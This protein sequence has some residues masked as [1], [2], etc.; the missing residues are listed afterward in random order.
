[1]NNKAKI[2]ELFQ[3]SINVKK[4]CLDNGFN[5][6]YSMGESIVSSVQKGGKIILCGNGGSAA[7]A[8]HLAAEMLI[9][10]RPMHRLA[11]SNE[12]QTTLIWMLSDAS[13]YLNGSIVPVD[14]GRTAW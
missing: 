9:R 1:M 3:H 8:Q 12:Y 7:D 11:Q 13:S 4:S 14:G 5:E 2:E 10:L 6:L